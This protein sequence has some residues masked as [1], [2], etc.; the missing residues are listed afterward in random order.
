MKKPKDN[1]ALQNMKIRDFVKLNFHT[2]II[3][4]D[5]LEVRYKRK[6][7]MHVKRA[8]KPMPPDKWFI[9]QEYKRYEYSFEEI[10]SILNLTKQEVINAI[11]KCNEEIEID[12]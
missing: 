4:Y 5:S 6:Y 2:S 8:N 3:F 1:F 7:F 9:Q 11:H 12:G 10:A